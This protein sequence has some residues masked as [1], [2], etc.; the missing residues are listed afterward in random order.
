MT[1]IE[2]SLLS[3]LDAPI[4]VGDPDGRA[5]YAN[6]AFQ[7]RFAAPG[8]RVVGRPLAELFAGGGREAVLSAVARVCQSGETARFRV[9]ER[10][11]GFA[12]VVSPI[13]AE[14]DRVG[15]V[16]LL[17]EE[18]EGVER[19]L[20]LHREIQDP[21]DALAVALDSM[22]EQTGGRRN[23]RYRGLVE[24]GLRA[25]GR[26]RKWCDE[27]GGVLVGVAGPAA[28]RFDP[29]E[30]V[31]HVRDRC[32]GEGARLTLL[33]PAALPAVRGDG[34][35]L[36]RALEALVR[37][38]RAQR[39]AP[40]GLTLGARALPA[41]E[42]GGVLVSLVE[43]F[44]GRP[45]ASVADAPEVREALAAL[46]AEAHTVADPALGRVLLLRLPAA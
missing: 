1:S 39:P 46:E 29:A 14:A 37:Q 22:L 26:I 42:G 19:L 16:I 36:E 44:P 3:F 15:V 12:A 27:I 13:V 28:P 41:G 9:R 33:A 8:A 35:R 21:I 23:E 2:H 43:Q 18:V 34:E 4:V 25:L 45:P 30:A 5:V 20:S 24:E 31:R 32:A 11:Q 7:T 10:G 17:K 40:A 38:R 6:P